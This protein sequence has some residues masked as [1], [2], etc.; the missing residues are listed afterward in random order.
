MALAAVPPNNRKSSFAIRT[1]VC[2]C[3]NNNESIVHT[4]EYMVKRSRNSFWLD[5]SFRG[6]AR[7]TRYHGKFI[8]TSSYITFGS[9]H[10]V[11][12]M[13]LGATPIVGRSDGRCVCQNVDNRSSNGRFLNPASLM[14]CS[15]CSV[16]CCGRWCCRFFVGLLPHLSEAVLLPKFSFRSVFR[17]RRD[18]RT[19]AHT[20]CCTH[21]SEKS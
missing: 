3:A 15:M 20:Q 2:L 12:R 7:A 9:T 18:A 11:S 1:R 4:H 17:C 21:R 5:D 10:S 16:L 14:W 8:E 13:C 6:N 19:R